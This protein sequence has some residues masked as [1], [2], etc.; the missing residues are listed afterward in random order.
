LKI[1]AEG[2]QLGKQILGGSAHDE[3][4]ALKKNDN[5]SYSAAGAS[6]SID[7]DISGHH[8]SILTD[9]W[10]IQFLDQ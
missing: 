9:F 10:L 8:G 6:Q 1:D 7:G 2:N 3:I 4:T 5:G